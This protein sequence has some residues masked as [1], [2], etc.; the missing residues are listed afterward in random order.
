MT[1]YSF[2]YWQIA[3]FRCSISADDPG[4]ASIDVNQGSLLNNHG[5]KYAL[6]ATD[7]NIGISQSTVMFTAIQK[8]LGITTQLEPNSSKEILFSFD[9]GPDPLVTGRIL[10]A[11]DS[12]DAKAV[13]FVVGNRIPKAEHMLTEILERGH[14]LGNHS[15]AHWLGKPP[16]FASYM[17]DLQQCQQR[18]FDVCGYMPFLYRPPLGVVTLATITCAH[19]LNLQIYKW[20]VD[21][22]DW[23]LRNDLAAQKQG[24]EFSSKVTQQDIILMHDNNIH[25]PVMLQQMLPRLSDSDFDMRSFVHRHTNGGQALAPGIS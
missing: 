23:R 4:V 6:S 2:Y 11:L 10:D 9:D 22:E 13:F 24:I 12:I 17:A 8:A 16:S 1:F 3:D 19:K 5:V 25:T 21:T 7:T 14:L 20:S 18:I 15:F